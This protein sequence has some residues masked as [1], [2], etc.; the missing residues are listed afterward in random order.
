MTEIM[1]AELT[2]AALDWAVAKCEGFIDDCNT[3]LHE[4][5]LT[6]VAEGSY[7]PSTDWTQGG[8]IIERLKISL[9]SP[10]P[11]HPD[12][13]AMTW[14]NKTKQ[15]GS[16]PLIAGMRCFVASKLGEKVEIPERLAK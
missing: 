2:G 11:I 4:A 12:W 14:L 3:W 5:T 6:E 8:L 16:T 7:H 9:A 13:T 1:T 15:D 10:S